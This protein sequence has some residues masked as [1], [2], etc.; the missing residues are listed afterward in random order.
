MK[1]RILAAILVYLTV[2]TPSAA[3]GSGGWQW[4]LEGHEVDRAFDLPDSPYGAG[5]RGVDLRGSVSEAVRSVAPGV[6]SYVGTINHVRIVVVNHGTERSTYQP[7]AASVRVGDAVT[8]GQPIGTLLLAGSHCPGAAC[9]HLGRKVGDAYL[10]PLA[11]MSAGGRFELINPDGPP[12]PPPFGSSGSLRRPV[13]GPITSP[14]G[15]RVH[16]I[17]HV[18]KLHDGTDFGVPCGTPVHA[19][20]SGV[21]TKRGYNSAYGNRIFLKH[22]G[23]LTTIYNHLSSQSVSVGQRVAVGR[24]VGHVGSTGLATGCHLHF[25]VLKGGKTTN[26]MGLL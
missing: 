11:L 4:P 16:P 25:M 10:D 2:F 19:A 7:V 18:R 8:A 15:M 1:T 5:N 14:Y 22:A 20:A 24:V 21:V 9:L 26:P 6:V 3:S 12:P 23:G 17:T 13:G